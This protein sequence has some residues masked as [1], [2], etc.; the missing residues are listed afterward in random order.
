MKN[1]SVRDK[2]ASLEDIYS[3]VVRSDD[4]IPNLLLELENLLNRATIRNPYFTPE[5][6]QCWWGKAKAGSLPLIVIARHFLSL[7]EALTLLIALDTPRNY[8][9][10]YTAFFQLVSLVLLIQFELN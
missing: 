4:N 2:N 1:S 7:F 8:F 10:L 5:W 3:E 9:S 6:I